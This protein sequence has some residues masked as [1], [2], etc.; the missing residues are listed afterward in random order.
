MGDALSSIE[1]HLKRVVT[2]IELRKVLMQMLAADAVN[3]P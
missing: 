2:E 3:V 1:D